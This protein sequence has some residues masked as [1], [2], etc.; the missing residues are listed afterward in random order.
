MHSPDYNPLNHANRRILLDLASAS[1]RHGL[2]TGRPIPVDLATLPPAL[3][4]PRATFVTLQ[5]HGELRGCIGCLEAHRPLAEDIAANAFAA[6]FRDSRFAPVTGEE[7]HHLEIHLSLLTPATPMVFRSEKDLLSQLAPGQDGL[8]MEE[9][10]HRG[11]FLPS[12][13]T[14]LPDPQ[15]FLRHLKLKAGLPG[16]Y[17]SPSL[18]VRRYRTESIQE[19]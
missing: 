12:V 11:T 9:G 16:N 13:W 10:P 14:S 4:G 1:I 2:A 18:E 5:K 17:W 8:I 7:F 3:T 19:P 6:A 15:D